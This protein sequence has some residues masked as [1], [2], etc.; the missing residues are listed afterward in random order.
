MVRVDLF[1]LQAARARYEKRSRRAQRFSRSRGVE[2][3]GTG[4]A[5]VPQRR[6]RSFSFL[7]P[8]DYLSSIGI[9]RSSSAAARLFFFLRLFS[10]FSTTGASL[11]KRLRVPPR[12]LRSFLRVFCGIEARHASQTRLL[13][14][15][16]S[17][18]TRRHE[19]RARRILRI[20]FP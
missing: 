18:L 2:I 11:G 17:F 16:A 15:E 1:R 20:L 14:Q 3:R 5:S 4:S 10:R 8:R 6:N 13:G 12:R 19:Q 9:D 7:R